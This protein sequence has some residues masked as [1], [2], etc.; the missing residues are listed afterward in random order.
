VKLIDKLYQNDLY[1]NTWDFPL[2]AFC[3]MALKT[4]TTKDHKVTNL[5]VM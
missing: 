1:A 2:R 3:C 5:D 4:W